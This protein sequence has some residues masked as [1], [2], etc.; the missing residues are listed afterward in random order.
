[1]DEFARLMSMEGVRP[2]DQAREKSRSLTKQPL[3]VSRKGIVA[4]PE[5][6]LVTTRG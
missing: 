3:P 6:A 1:M 5:L 2:L 4:P